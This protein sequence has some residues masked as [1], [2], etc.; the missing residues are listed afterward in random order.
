MSYKT[1]R[2]VYN[3]AHESRTYPEDQLI[4]KVTKHI[5]LRKKNAKPNG[6]SYVKQ[7]MFTS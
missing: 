1:Q 4:V 2:D 3:V 6:K 7:T 5:T